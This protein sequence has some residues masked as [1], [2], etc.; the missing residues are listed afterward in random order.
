M[1]K[2]QN[3]WIALYL[4]GQYPWFYT[5]PDRLNFFDEIKLE[6]PTR[7]TD[8]ILWQYQTKNDIEFFYS[9]LNSFERNHK[10][11]YDELLKKLW[12]PDEV[13][14]DPRADKKEI[15]KEANITNDSVALKLSNILH[16]SI[17]SKYVSW[18]KSRLYDWA[19]VE[20]FNILNDRLKN[21]CNQSLWMWEAVEMDAV[22]IIF[23]QTLNTNTFN[24]KRWTET[25]K[26][27]EVWLKALF[28]W[29]IKYYRNPSA[30]IKNSIKTEN[31]FIE[32]MILLSSLLKKMDNSKIWK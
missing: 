10:D 31:E 12:V 8:T 3:H 30:H 19:F 4:S 16:S 14:N 26:W 9:L 15:V 5:L 7:Y 6:N 1:D 17:V 18:I 11:K 29:I 24:F 13:K 20:A 21:Y 23:T 27:M 28:E 22:D 25:E 32:S 2:T